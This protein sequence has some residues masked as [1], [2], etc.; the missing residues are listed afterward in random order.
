MHLKTLQLWENLDFFSGLFIIMSILWIDGKAKIPTEKEKIYPKKHVTH[1]HWQAE[2]NGKYDY[3]SDYECVFN[4]PIGDERQSDKR[5][6]S[7]QE[8]KKEGTK[9]PIVNLAHFTNKNASEEIVKSGTFRGGKPKKIDQDN[10]G[11]DVEARFSWWSPIFEEKER[12]NVRVHLGNAIQPFLGEE[13]DRKELILTQFATTD[14]FKPNPSRYGQIYFKYG[15][16]ELCKYYQSQQDSAGDVQYKILGTFRYK[17]EVMH[18]VLVCSQADGD[19]RFK[20]YPVVPEKD[21]EAVI[22]RN[23]NGEWVWKPQATTNQ[24]VRLNDC[25]VYPKYCRWEHV[26]FAF[27]IP[28][29]MEGGIMVDDP[30]GHRREIETD[31]DES[32]EDSDQET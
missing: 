11:E 16:N 20:D 28:D 27:Y 12:N 21:E 32:N 24:I 19:G 29:E 10:N 4:H 5:W 25:S 8:A 30:A 2:W 9:V 18:A 15:I 17:Q 22:T 14:A 23:G 26:A 7:L 31:V 6:P 13:G 1:N 3:I